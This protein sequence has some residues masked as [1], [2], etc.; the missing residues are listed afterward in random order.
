METQLAKLWFVSQRI[1]RHVGGH[2]SQ[3]LFPSDRLRLYPQHASA[4]NNLGTL[5]QSPKEAESFY[6]KA[7][8]I[9]PQHNRALFNLGNLCK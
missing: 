7:L 1:T 4:M 8:V 2:G 6:R 9:N 3:L 5:T